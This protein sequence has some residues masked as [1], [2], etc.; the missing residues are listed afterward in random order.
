MPRQSR[1]VVSNDKEVQKA[2]RSCAPGV[3]RDYRV[4]RFA[5]PAA[6]RRGGGGH[7]GSRVQEPED[8]QMGEGDAR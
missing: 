5:G 4:A 8:R 2:I 1:Y 3:R 6:P 7:L